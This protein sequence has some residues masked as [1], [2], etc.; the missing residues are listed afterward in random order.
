VAAAAD[1]DG[2][3]YADILVGAQGHDAGA[4][5]DAN[6][7]RAYLYQG[8][9]E[10]QIAGGVS[11]IPR[12]ERSDAFVPIALSGSSDSENEF[13]VKAL[14]R[15]AA[16]RG[17]VRLQWQARPLGTPFDATGIDVSA[18]QDTGAPGLTGSA[19]SFDESVAG[20]AGGTFYHW[21]LRAV[22]N[23]PFFPSSPWMSL[24]GNN[25]TETK[26]RTLGCIDRDGDG[27][28]DLGDVTC[29]SLVPDCND[30]DATI[31][32]TP[33][34]IR[35]VRFVTKVAQVWDPPL[36]P[37]A[38]TGALVYDTLRA[39]APSN[40]LSAACAETSDGPNTTAG[41]PLPSAG[42]R[43]FYL[44]RA[45]NACPQGIGSFG[46]DSN[47]APRPARSCPCRPGGA[48]RRVLPRGTCR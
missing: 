34:E 5:T 11:R 32:G 24:A 47:G 42:Q 33:G 13:R 3:G 45:K 43:F 12:Q 2:D 28:G 1:V 41:D 19:T 22:S 38:L 37:G 15:T 4:G 35:N 25:V 6:R 20:L 8:N 44:G 10:G 26:L 40:F 14:G 7:G 18:P 17:K 30:H 21:R 29:L 46:T 16:G 39:D 23:D 36:E 27:F 31:W 9:S 48:P